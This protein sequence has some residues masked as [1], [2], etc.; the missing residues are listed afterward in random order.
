MSKIPQ[1][2]MEKIIIFI[3]IFIILLGLGIAGKMDYEDEVL[4]EKTY[5]EN[6]CQGIHPD[7]KGWNVD[8]LT[9]PKN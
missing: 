5:K 2:F 4:F 3:S 6:V 1:T 9:N 7:Y 8:C